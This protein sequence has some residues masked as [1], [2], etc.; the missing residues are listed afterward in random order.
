MAFSS[1]VS[2]RA[3]DPKRKGPL[4][5]YDGSRPAAVP[6]TSD[7]TATAATPILMTFLTTARLRCAAQS[8]AHAA[9]GPVRIARPI[10][11]IAQDLLA[12]SAPAGEKMKAVDGKYTIP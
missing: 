9:A 10:Q 6:P 1:G 5:R 8:V 7:I 4:N 2:E 11:L 3:S 12:P